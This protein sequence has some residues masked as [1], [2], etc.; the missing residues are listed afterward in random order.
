[1]RLKNQIK[2]IIKKIL[3]CFCIPLALTSCSDD[4][5]I[6]LDKVNI[7]VTLKEQF[8]QEFYSDASTSIFYQFDNLDAFHSFLTNNEKFE[9][10]N[11]SDITIFDKTFFQKNCLTLLVTKI[12]TS[13]AFDHAEFDADLQ[14]IFYYYNIDNLSTD[15]ISIDYLFHIVPSKADLN[16]EISVL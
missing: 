8:T 10:E 1:M 2:F 16:F 4:L 5:L 3:F 7:S 15:G 14:T 13:D 11:T 9:V 12:G 6:Q